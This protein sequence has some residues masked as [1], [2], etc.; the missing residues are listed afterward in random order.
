MTLDEAKTQ[1][2]AI[3]ARTDIGNAQKTA[4]AMRVKAQFRRANPDA[5]IDELGV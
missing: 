5:E 1:I 4:L 3:Y 2:E